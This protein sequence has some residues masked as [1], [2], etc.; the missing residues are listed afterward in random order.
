MSTAA[1]RIEVF[2]DTMNWINSDPALS[3]SIPIAKKNTTVFYENDYPTF[4]DLDA[5]I[6]QKLREADVPY[7][8]TQLRILNNY[9]LS[10]KPLITIS[11]DI[12]EPSFICLSLNIN[13]SML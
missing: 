2:Q 12:S 5:L 9:S 1:E 11:I 13:S 3:S 6:K 4:D 8:V 10:T 7:D